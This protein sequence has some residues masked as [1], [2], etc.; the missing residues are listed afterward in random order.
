MT[1]AAA[2]LALAVSLVT[3][4][5]GATLAAQQP[6]QVAPSDAVRARP[7]DVAS[8]DAIVGALY[9]VI[10][11]PAGQPRDWARF[12]SLFAPGAR[13][14]PTAVRPDG[15]ASLTSLGVEDYIARVRERFERDGFFEVEIGRQTA[16]FD[17]VTQLF[18]A[19]ASR[20]SADDAT[21]FARGVNSIQLF[22]DGTRWWIV[23]VY[24]AAE[25]PGALI[26]EGLLRKN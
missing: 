4:R 18:S 23:T 7:A 5:P 2:P 22:H 8:I 11:G 1:R 3:T 6:A 14:I 24:W 20:R 10:S 26:P 16:T 9:E 25:R 17:A 13:L 19:Y 15:R 12:R 21:P